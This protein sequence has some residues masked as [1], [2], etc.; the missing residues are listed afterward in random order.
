MKYFLGKQDFMKSHGFD[1]TKEW[2]YEE[3][4]AKL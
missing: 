4:L 3:Y 2:F 1:W